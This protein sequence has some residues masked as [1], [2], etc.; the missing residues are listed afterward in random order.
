MPR[1]RADDGGHHRRRQQ[2]GGHRHPAQLLTLGAA[3]MA[4]AHHQR[5]DVHQ[6]GEL[7]KDQG[8]DAGDQD[9]AG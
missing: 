9:Q 6:D 2:A 7:G 3:S 5:G 4:K 8:G 1:E